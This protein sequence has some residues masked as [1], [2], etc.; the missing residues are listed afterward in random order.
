MAGYEKYARHVSDVLARG[1]DSDTKASA[2]GPVPLEFHLYS[3]AL[4]ILL[5]ALCFPSQAASFDLA[6]TCFVFGLSRD[7]SRRWSFSHL[8]SRT[9]CVRKG[10]HE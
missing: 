7:R 5:S 6:A 4:R 9:P 8:V 3:S 2:Y 1:I 10:S